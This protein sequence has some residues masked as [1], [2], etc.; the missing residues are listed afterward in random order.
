VVRRGNSSTGVGI[1][2]PQK[3]ETLIFFR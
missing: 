3:K 2:T 1:L